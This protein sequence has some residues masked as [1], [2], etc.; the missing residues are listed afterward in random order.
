MEKPKSWRRTFSRSFSDGAI[1]Y[2]FRFE[3]HNVVGDYFREKNDE[4]II[5]RFY[6]FDGNF[7]EGRAVS[8]IAV[9]YIEFW[10]NFESDRGYKLNRETLELKFVMF[11]KTENFCSCSVYTT[12]PDYFTDMENIRRQRQEAYNKKLEK[13]KILIFN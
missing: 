4:V 6:G 13:N 8:S 11:G 3:G 12:P 2:D 5:A 7:D 9:D 10:W 1:V